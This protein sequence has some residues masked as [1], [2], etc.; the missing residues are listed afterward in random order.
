MSKGHNRA[1]LVVLSLKN[2][3][4][5]KVIDGFSELASVSTGEDKLCLAGGG[6]S[7]FCSLVNVAVSVTR[8]GDRL[9]PVAN[10]GLYRV[11]KYGRAENSSVKDSADSAVGALPHLAEVVFLNTL[12]VG[13]DSSALYRNAVFL[14]CV[15][16]VKG[17]LILG[18]LAFYQTEIVILG[19]QINEGKEQLV[20]YHLPKNS[21]H[22][23]A[24]HLDERRCHF[25]FFHSLLPRLCG[26][27]ILDLTNNA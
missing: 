2:A 15:S 22:F 13:S 10:G 11:D 23:V 16:A 17:H 5:L 7:V 8:D 1:V 21:C 14:R 18:S 27:S 24:V 6:D 25:D 3:A 20:L 12:L 4:A 9:L 26:Q 19:V